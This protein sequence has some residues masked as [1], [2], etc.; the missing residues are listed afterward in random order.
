M[1]CTGVNTTH[2]FTPAQSG[3]DSVDTGTVEWCGVWCSVVMVVDR[4]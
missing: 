3:G 1:W 4:T 2:R